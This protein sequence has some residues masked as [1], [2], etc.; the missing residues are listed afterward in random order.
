MRG[1]ELIG[2]GQYLWET[3]SLLSTKR[4]NG[5]TPDCMVCPSV[6]LQSE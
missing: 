2:T 4:Q 3:A 6:A 1:W 5:N